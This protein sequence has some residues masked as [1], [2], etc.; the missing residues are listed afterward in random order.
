MRL[1]RLLIVV[2]IVVGAIGFWRGWF[3]FGTTKDPAGNQMDLHLT[4]DKNK[5]R[6][7]LETTKEK[8]NNATQ[9]TTQPVAP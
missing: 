2:V 8:F 4:V 9:P 5:I 7:D 6:Q 1:F 3:S